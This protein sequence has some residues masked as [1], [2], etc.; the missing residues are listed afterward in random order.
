MSVRSEMRSIPGGGKR[1]FALTCALFVGL[2]TAC[3]G[4]SGG[5]SSSSNA[6]CN[7]SGN[8]PGVTSGQIT[9]GATLPLTTAGPSPQEVVDASQA[10]YDMVN[11]AGGVKGRKIKFIAR[12]DQYNP[13]IA[14]QQMRNLVQQDRIFLVAGGQGTPN[15]LAEAPF[16][17]GQK[18]PAIAPYAPSSDLGNMKYPYVYMTAVNYITEFEIMTKYVLDSASPHSLSLV[19]VQ[20]NVGDDSKQGMQKA[21]GS[22]KVSLQYIPEQPGTPDFTPIATQLKS[23]AS[24]WVFLILTP[25]D[26][27]GLLK[28]MQ[29]IGFTPH[30]AAWAG[31]GDQTYIDAFGS[32]SQGMIVAQELAL[33][34]APDPDV[35]KFVQDFTKQTGKA[36]SGFNSSLGWAQAELTVKALKDAPALTRDCVVHALNGVKDFKTGVLPPITFGP[37]QRQGVNAVG[38]VQIKGTSVVQA[39]PFKAV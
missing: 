5:Q 20:G 32:V 2:V 11:K 27:G 35:Q 4:G 8:A 36:P 30:L 16:L 14:L 21:I 9:L 1:W 6:G 19:G 24:D 15:F 38:L 13:S 26:T 31:M 18:V 3:G 37:S 23:N 34:N 28:A 29:R 10:Y 17:N 7:T 39:A 33:P 22:N 12:D 25:T